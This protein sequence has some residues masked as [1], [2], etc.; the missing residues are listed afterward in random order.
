MKNCAHNHEKKIRYCENLEGD[1]NNAVDVNFDKKIRKDQACQFLCITLNGIV[2]FCSDLYCGFI[3]CPEIV[4]QLGYLTHLN[5]GDLVMAANGFVMQD[6]LASV[7]AK[8]TLPHFING[9][10][11]FTKE[12]SDHNKKIASLRIHV[13]KI[14]GEIE[15][16]AFV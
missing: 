16:L 3:S 1:E 11:Q 14:Y 5:K 8:L 6:E 15:K 10:K 9:M 2:S 13:E 12:E 7:E 4:K